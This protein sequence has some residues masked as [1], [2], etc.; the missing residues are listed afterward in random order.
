MSV[1]LYFF[2]SSPASQRLRLAL[3][4]KSITVREH[5]LAYFD[6]ETFFEL[7]VAR[8][9]PQLKLA[10][11][12]LLSD[13][14]GILWRMDELFPDAPS[15]VEGVIDEA[16]WRALLDWRHGVDSI[17]ARLYAPA[18]PA[19]AEIGADEAAMEDY[20]AALPRRFG[21][22][23]E[24]L[25]NDRYA[26]YTQLAQQSRL[27]ELARHLSQ[28]GFYMGRISIA[29][30]LLTADLYPLQ[31]L[32]GVALPIDLLYYLQRVERACEVSLSEGLL[33]KI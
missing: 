21:L 19:Y 8:E 24:A 4:Y 31:L 28:N 7:G 20:K 29:D 14:E 10:D 27:P 25:A 30:M 26:G 16:A 22:S 11:G 15:L 12:R 32:D 2:H 17:L 18:L 33:V 23:A 5:A 9:V 3:G 1:D 6:D 13:S